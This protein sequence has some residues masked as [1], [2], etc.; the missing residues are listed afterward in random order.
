MLSVH[1]LN[2]LITKSSVQSSATWHTCIR[3]YGQEKEG[4]PFYTLGQVVTSFTSD[5]E[6]KSLYHERPETHICDLPPISK[7]G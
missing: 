2:R 4:S 7:H 3:N 1:L 6:A 5:Q